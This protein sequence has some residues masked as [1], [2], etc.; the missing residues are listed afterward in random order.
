VPGL[1]ANG[2]NWALG[3]YVATGN[4]YRMVVAQSGDVLTLLIDFAAPMLA[5]AVTVHAGCSHLIA[6]CH[7]KFANAIRFGGFPYIPKR[8]PFE[9][10]ID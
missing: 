4:D 5:Q 7:S 10:G 1:S 8:N 6:V 2:V 3:G 9:T